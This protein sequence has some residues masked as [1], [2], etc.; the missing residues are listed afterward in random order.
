MT[1]TESPLSRWMLR[2]ES[3]TALDAGVA[4]VRPVVQAVTSNERIAG[5][6]QGRWLGHAAHPLVVMA[7]IGMWMSAGL[8]QM[9]AVPGSE[10]SARTLTA[11]GI[12]C[13]LPAAGTGLAEIVNA[14]ERGK[15]VGVVHASLNVA[16]L[17]AEVL[18]WAS[19]RA[20]NRSRSTLWS[21]AG[22]GLV[23]VSGY[24]GGHLSVARKVGTRDP[25]FAAEDAG[26]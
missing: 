15:R 20:G 11:A 12:L 16:A 5:V 9:A 2:L 23:G 17:G 10:R 25:A 8:L 22:L 26:A 18:A 13:A 3:A 19:S 21:L 7:P 24:L 1:P 14:D 4:I 6:L